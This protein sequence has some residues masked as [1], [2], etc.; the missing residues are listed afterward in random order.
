MNASYEAPWF[1]ARR[2]EWWRSQPNEPTWQRWLNR[3]KLPWWGVDR[4]RWRVDGS[5]S[6]FDARDVDLIDDIRGDEWQVASRLIYETFQWRDLF[7]DT[8]FGTRMRKVSVFNRSFAGT[9]SEGGDQETSTFLAVGSFEANVAGTFDPQLQNLGRPE[10]DGDYQLIRYDLGTSQYL[11]PLLFP[12]AWKDPSTPRTSTLS[13][14]LAVGFRG[15]YAF[16]YRLIPQASQVIGGL[17]SVRG[18][19]PSVSVGDSVWIASAE[20]RFH[21]PRSLPI[22]REPLDLPVIGDFRAAPQQVYG[23]PDWDFVIRAFVDHRYA[24]RRIRPHLP[25]LLRRRT[26]HP[27]RANTARGQRDAARRRVRRRVPLSAQADRTRRLGTC[28]EG[29][30]L[31]GIRRLPGRPG[32]RRAPLSV[33]RGVLRCVDPLLASSER[34]GAARWH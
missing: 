18:Y 1:G 24:A 12:E 20:Y 19:D 5:W 8:F 30:W 29:R 4:L 23:R 13:H 34:A 6:R 32:R 15:Q 21:L 25:G 7:V 33:Q 2:P 10:V 11:E 3:D 14:E 27:L 16:D 17:Y 22:A 31:R 9:D 28:P 26:R